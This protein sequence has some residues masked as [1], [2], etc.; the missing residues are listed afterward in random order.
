MEN[1]IAENYHKN[2]QM[3]IESDGL[4]SMT[5]MYEDYGKPKFKSPRRY[6]SYKRT[7][8]QIEYAIKESGYQVEKVI[9]YTSDD[10]LVSGTLAMSYLNQLDVKS[11]FH[12]YFERNGIFKTGGSL[13]ESFFNYY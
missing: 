4:I 2:M 5:K 13:L 3:I 7:K 9:Q 6:L 8:Q 12:F 1:K 10:I 11:Y